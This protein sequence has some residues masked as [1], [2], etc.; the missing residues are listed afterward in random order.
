MLFARPTAEAVAS[1]TLSVH[2]MAKKRYEQS[3][4]PISPVGGEPGASGGL[5]A[6]VGSLLVGFPG[7]YC[8]V[9]LELAGRHA[10]N[11]AA[12]DN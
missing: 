1:E 11:A 7:V 12:D 6:I 9:K 3:F 4:L 10:A 2:L 5:D 8:T